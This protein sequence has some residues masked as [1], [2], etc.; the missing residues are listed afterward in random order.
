MQDHSSKSSVEAWGSGWVG[1]VSWVGC[2]G[3]H[4][5]VLVEVCEGALLGR[6]EVEQVRVQARLAQQRHQV[7]DALRRQVVL[8]KHTHTRAFTPLYLHMTSVL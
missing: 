2:A 3:P 7:V 1:R 8:G 6:E 4:L 5:E